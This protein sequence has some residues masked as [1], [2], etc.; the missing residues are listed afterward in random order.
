[1]TNNTA[2]KA[3]PPDADIWSMLRE[4]NSQAEA[5]IKLFV[6]DHVTG[7]NNRSNSYQAVAFRETGTCYKYL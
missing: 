5:A 2:A 6:F 7:Q 4:D 3:S 1:M